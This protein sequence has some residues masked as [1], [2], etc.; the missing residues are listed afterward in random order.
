MAKI[1]VVIMLHSGIPKQCPLLVSVRFSNQKNIRGNG[2][3]EV[4]EKENHKR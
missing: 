3:L 2:E 1:I 4:S